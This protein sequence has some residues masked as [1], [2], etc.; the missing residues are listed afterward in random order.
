[1]EGL[2]HVNCAN[3]D[4][5]RTDECKTRAGPFRANRLKDLGLDRLEDVHHLK[6]HHVELVLGSEMDQWSLARRSLPANRKGLELLKKQLLDRVA[7]ENTPSQWHW[8]A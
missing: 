1:M 6:D 4:L 7:G 3:W 5:A 2:V 8:S